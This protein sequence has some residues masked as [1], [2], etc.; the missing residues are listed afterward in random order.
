MP[1]LTTGDAVYPSCKT[2]T[3][4][5]GKLDI[6]CLIVTDYANLEDCN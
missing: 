4:Q 6:H 5:T 1:P 3:S 2:E